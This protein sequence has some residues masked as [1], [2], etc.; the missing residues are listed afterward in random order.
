MDG[1]EDPNGLVAGGNLYVIDKLS[2][3]R[4]RRL[5]RSDRQ[6]AVRVCAP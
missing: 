4:R 6:S 3:C 5:S 2:E 1:R